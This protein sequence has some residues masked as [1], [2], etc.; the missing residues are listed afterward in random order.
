MVIVFSIVG[1]SILVINSFSIMNGGREIILAPTIIPIEKNSDI[2]KN[3][4]INNQ[5]FF[6]TNT[7]NFVRIFKRWGI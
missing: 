6:L 5:R 3:P 1:S 4:M 2:P 7:T